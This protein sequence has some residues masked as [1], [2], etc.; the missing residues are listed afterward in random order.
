MIREDEPLRPSERISTLAVEAA[1]TLSQH[2]GIDQRRL[3]E[4]LRGDLDWIVMK[5]LEKDRTRRYESASAFAADVQRYLHDE[6]VDACPPSTGYHLRK[7]AVRNKAVLATAAAVLL[8]LSAATIVST[9]LAVWALRER[10]EKEQARSAA[11]IDKQKALDAA[12][13]QAK[14]AAQEREARQDEAA[15]RRRAEAV[16]EFLAKVFE[17]PIQPLA[18]L[19]SHPSSLPPIRNQ[20]GQGCRQSR[21]SHTPHTPPKRCREIGRQDR[22]RV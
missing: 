11:V 13:A 1:S 17:A 3:S 18:A 7:L 2:R 8:T 9:S 20:P 12:E 19:C 14:S 10:N 6:P 16:A 5:A 22:M 4:T 21:S 15:Q